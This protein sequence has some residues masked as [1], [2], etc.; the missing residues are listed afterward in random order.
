[1]VI[2]LCRR[3]AEALIDAGKA[4]GYEAAAAWL[5]PAKH[6]YLAAR[7]TRE[8]DR[9]IAGLLKRHRQKYKLRPLLEALRSREPIAKAS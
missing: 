7:R 5:A 4:E 1:R 3:H 2:P 8:W 9:Y 6:A